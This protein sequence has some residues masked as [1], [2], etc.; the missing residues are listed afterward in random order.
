[1]P[2][3]KS[4]E[5]QQ[6]SDT[7]LTGELETLE[8]QYNAMHFEHVLKGLDNPLK[9][10]EVRRDIARI[11]T[12]LRRREIESMGPTATANRSKIRARRRKG[13]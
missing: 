5:L 12:E 3:N 13:K 6:L 4:L 11:K 10:R 7:D 8:A 9:L 1:M 2:S